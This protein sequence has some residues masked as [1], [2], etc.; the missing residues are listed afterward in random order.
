MNAYKIALLV[1]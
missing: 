1:H